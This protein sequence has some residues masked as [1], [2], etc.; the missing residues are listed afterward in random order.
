MGTSLRPFQGLTPTGSE[1]LN[2]FH[3]PHSFSFRQS[4]MRNIVCC[5]LAPFS[6]LILSFTFTPTVQPKQ[7]G[8]AFLYFLFGYE[9]NSP[10]ACGIVDTKKPISVLFLRLHALHSLPGA[11]SLLL[12]IL[13]DRQKLTFSQHFIFN[14]VILQS[15]RN[16]RVGWTEHLV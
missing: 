9:V 11:S 6:Y 12:D 2:F 7:K 10:W 15:F 1:G 4:H 8:R 5:F 14:L 16:R 3:V 13:E